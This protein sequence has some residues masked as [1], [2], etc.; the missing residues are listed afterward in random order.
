MPEIIIGLGEVRLERHCGFKIGNGVANLASL[1]STLPRFFRTAGALRLRL[2]ALS[3]K[4][5]LQLA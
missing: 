1:T 2:S 3:L 4:R 5:F